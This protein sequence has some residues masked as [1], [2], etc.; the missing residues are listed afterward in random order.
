MKLRMTGSPAKD[1]A[2]CGSTDDLVHDAAAAHALLQAIEEFQKDWEAYG[3]P[4]PEA[5]S[6][7][8]AE[9]MAEWGFADDD[10]R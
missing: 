2:F 4:A 3:A 6:E 8:A 10:A 7:R 1:H 9:L 5:I